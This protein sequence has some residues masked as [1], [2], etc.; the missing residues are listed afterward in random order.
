MQMDTK[1]EFIM[2]NYDI[3]KLNRYC[4]HKECMNIP[5]KEVLLFE[6]DTINKLRRDI[7]SLYLCDDHYN[8]SVRFLLDEL[9]KIC[10]SRK[11]IK[12]EVFDTGYVTY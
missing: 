4:N 2:L 12:A 9:N 10:E 3:K 6:F 7:V 1:M 5:S 11:V 8:A